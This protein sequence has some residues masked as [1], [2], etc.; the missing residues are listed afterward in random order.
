MKVENPLFHVESLVLQ[1]WQSVVK[2]SAKPLLCQGVESDIALARDSRR[3]SA[4]KNGLVSSKMTSEEKDTHI[5]F[6]DMCKLVHPDSA[7]LYKLP[8]SS[9]VQV[10]AL[11][12]WELAP[13]F[14]LD[15]HLGIEF[16]NASAD[17]LL[18]KCNPFLSGKRRGDSVDLTSEA[19]TVSTD[20]SVVPERDV[21]E[22]DIVKE[23]E[24]NTSEEF[25]LLKT[26]GGNAWKAKDQGIFSTHPEGVVASLANQFESR[27]NQR[28]GSGAEKHPSHWMCIGYG[29]YVKQRQRDY[30]RSFKSVLVQ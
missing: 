9:R 18:N 24:D 16:P 27:S 1:L 14:A 28:P 25:E 21:D 20:S 12:N 23:E 19:Q 26:D 13:T 10:V 17:R 4:A 29:R 30:T 6:D 22:L 15:E 8:T 2:F 11:A 7:A 5:A 3:V